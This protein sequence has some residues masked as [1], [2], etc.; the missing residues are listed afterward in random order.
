MIVDLSEKSVFAVTVS[1]TVGCLSQNQVGTAS[2]QKGIV[3]CPG[4]MLLKMG[5][6]TPELPSRAGRGCLTNWSKP[7]QLSAAYQ[8]AETT[9]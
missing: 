2:L 4:E 6:G 5:K 9:S 7:L 3:P 1:L 8:S